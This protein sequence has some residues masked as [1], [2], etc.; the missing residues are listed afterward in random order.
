MFFFLWE[1]DVHLTSES[2]KFKAA[3]H[4]PLYLQRQGQV[5]LLKELK[6]M[7]KSISYEIIAIFTTSGLHI[8][9]SGNDG[10]KSWKLLELAKK[11]HKC[12]VPSFIY[13]LFSFWNL[14]LI[15]AMFQERKPANQKFWLVEIKGPCFVV[16]VYNAPVRL[17]QIAM[18]HP[19]ESA[20]INSNSVPNFVMWRKSNQHIQSRL[21]LQHCNRI[22]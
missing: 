18:L 14:R 6:L 17:Q 20:S 9:F 15:P 2:S 12:E 4:W 3:N 8:C 13:I 22:H 11:L 10:W 19:G 1:T 7:C 21:K 16:R 5:G